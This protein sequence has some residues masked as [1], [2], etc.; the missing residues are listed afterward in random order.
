MNNF[1]IRGLSFSTSQNSKTSGNSW[2]NNVSLT[3]FA[4]GQYFNI[5]SNN[6]VNKLCTGIAKVLSFVRN[7]IE[8][9]IKLSKYK[10]E[11]CTLCRGIMIFLKKITCSSLKGTAN[12]LIILNVIIKVPSQD[13]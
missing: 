13:I 4:N 10:F 9:L 11:V 1:P 6:Y 2:R 7:S 8:H 5:P 12:P 3:K